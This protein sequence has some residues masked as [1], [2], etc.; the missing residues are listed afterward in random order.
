MHLNIYLLCS[1]VWLFSLCFAPVYNSTE[2]RSKCRHDSHSRIHQ[3]TNKKFCDPSFSNQTAGAIT[4]VMPRFVEILY[5]CFPSFV[6]K[7]VTLQTVLQNN[8]M[9]PFNVPPEIVLTP[10]KKL[11][12]F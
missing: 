7:E 12:L 11:I 9:E 8:V 2:K 4:Q 1:A 3:K 10:F 6:S 5:V